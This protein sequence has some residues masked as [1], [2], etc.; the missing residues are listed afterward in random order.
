MTMGKTLDGRLSHPYI[1]WV[2]AFINFAR[3]IMDL[4]SNIPCPCIHCGNCYRQSPNTVRIHL[5]HRGIIFPTKMRSLFRFY[6]FSAQ[7]IIGFLNG[8]L[9]RYFI[10]ITLAP[11]K[12]KNI[13]LDLF[14]LSS[15]YEEIVDCNSHN[16]YTGTEYYHSS[17]QPLLQN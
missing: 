11:Q 8:H 5:L 12:V 13:H 3:V 14:L 17:P 7:L 2:N 16:E 15:Q 9:L 10:I 4:S 1:E 6:K